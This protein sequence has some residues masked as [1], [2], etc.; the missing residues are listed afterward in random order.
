MDI[1][2]KFGE[3]VAVPKN[4][5]REGSPRLITIGQIAE[6]HGVSRS[7]VHTYRRRPTFPQPVPVEGSTR[8]HYRADEV[9]A[10]F[11]ANPPQQGKRTDLA[12]RDEGVPVETRSVAVPPG[13]E[14]AAAQEFVEWLR[15][16][17]SE[18]ERIARAAG[19]RWREL[20]GNWVAAAEGDHR[21]AMVLAAGER[22]HIVAHD[23]AR[24]LRE[25]DAKRQI[26]GLYNSAVEERAT[27]RARMREVIDSDR[28]E[29]GRLHN[30][31]TRLI[32]T[33]RTLTPVVRLLALPYADRPGY[34]EDWRP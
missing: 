34:R 24:V 29:F 1:V 17:L 27:L 14:L 15:S 9:A 28:D 30:E 11:E 13:V 33:A 21:V 19:G 26:L 22:A 18:D 5:E 31:E 23:P 20:S 12:P 2:Q 16:Q 7:S 32:E 3:D 25:I 10:W 4:P 6:E 8:T